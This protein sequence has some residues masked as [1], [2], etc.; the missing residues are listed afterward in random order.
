MEGM[1]VLK[2]LAFLSAIAF[3]FCGAASLFLPPPANPVTPP[4]LA[5]G[6]RMQVSADA[7]AM[8]KRACYDCHSN[9]TRWPIYSRVWPASAIVY[10]DVSRARQTMN[11]SDWPRLDDPHEARRAAGL[12]MASCAAVESG[13]MPRRQY[14]ALHPDAKVSKEEAQKFCA[15]TSSAIKGIRESAAH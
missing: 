14:L 5:I 13:L 6:S 2:W 8:L 9:E 3:V 7:Q 1:P 15:W 12:L 11:F 10:S 4:K